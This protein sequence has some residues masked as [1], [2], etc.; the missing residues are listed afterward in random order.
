[1]DISYVTEDGQLRSIG[2]I[3]HREFYAYQLQQ[4]HNVYSLLL[5]GGRLFH[6]YAVDAYCVT[7][8]SRFRWLRRN[9]DRF[10]AEILCGLQDAVNRGDTDASL[11]GKRTILPSS[12]VGGPRYMMQIYQDSMAICRAMGYL[13]LFITFTCNPKW[14]EIRHFL[15]LIPGQP[16][17]DR[18][19]IV[20]RVFMMKLQN[21]RDDLTKRKHFGRVVAGTISP[22]FR[23]I[24]KLSEKN[25][26][27]SP[28]LII[29]LNC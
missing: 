18:P 22:T 5:L 15:D 16:P 25:I 17:E 2:T 3:T 19:D 29:F 8:E 13:D 27:S 1:M 23:G 21:F 12:F 7:L 10:R 14:P 20:D 4:R 26:Y 28:S 24:L 6:E 9:R 11:Y